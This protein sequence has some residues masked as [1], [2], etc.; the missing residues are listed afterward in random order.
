MG[1]LTPDPTASIEGRLGQ[2]KSQPCPHIVTSIRGFMY[3]RRI[4]VVKCRF[5]FYTSR[6]AENRLRQCFQ[7]RESL[8]ALVHIEGATGPNFVGADNCGRRDRTIAHPRAHRTRVEGS[9]SFEKVGV[10]R[11]VKTRRPNAPARLPSNGP[12]HEE[13][14]LRYTHNFGRHR[15]QLS[16]RFSALFALRE[17]ELRPF[18]Y[19]TCGTPS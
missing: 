8:S 12:H 1:C 10:P 2:T 3:P 14:E 15:C 5:I 11:S 13:R 19:S 16:G 9:H 17:E 7:S 18:V 6:P 4:Y